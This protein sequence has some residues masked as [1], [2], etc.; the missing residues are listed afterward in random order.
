[1]IITVR[2][3]SQVTLDD[4]ANFRAFKVV[5]EPA[6]AT[7][8]DVQAALKGVATLT[9]RDTAWVSADALR[10]WPDVKD[11]AAWQQGFDAMIEKARPHGWVDEHNRTVKAH[12]EWAS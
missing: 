11:D 10:R 8:G 5:V 4:R 6:Q 7:L 12:V 1:M 9:D 3:G 2:G